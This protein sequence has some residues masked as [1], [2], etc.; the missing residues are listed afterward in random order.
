MDISKIPV[1]FTI[2]N[3]VLEIK[4]QRRKKKSSLIALQ[5]IGY[6]NPHAA[7]KQFWCNQCDE[8]VC[9]ACVVLKHTKD[10]NCEIKTVEEMVSSQK[11]IHEENLGKAKASHEKIVDAI[12]NAIDVC[13][14]SKSLLRYDIE[15]LKN[16][17]KIASLELKNF[18]LI[19]S[20]MKGTCSNV[21]EEW[22]KYSSLSENVKQ[23]TNYTQL[24]V[25]SEEVLNMSVNYLQKDFFVRFPAKTW[26]KK[27]LLEVM[28]LKKFMNIFIDLSFSSVG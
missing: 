15:S 26:N 25:A 20:K 19:Q 10:S 8:W 9:G 6:C 22:S 28:S 3:I 18:D 14:T 27:L 23:A 11:T 13:E 16:K 5:A 12:L 7:P 4:K 24:E 17:I 21:N 2:L 1:S